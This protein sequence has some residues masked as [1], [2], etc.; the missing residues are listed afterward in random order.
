QNGNAVLD[1]A[2]S[3]TNASGQASMG[4]TYAATASISAIQASNPTNP[5][6]FATAYATGVGADALNIISGNGQAGSEGTHSVQPLVV[7]VRNAA[8]QVVAGRTINWTSIAGAA[9]PDTP[10]SVTN[11]SGRASMGFTYGSLPSSTITATDA[12]NGH[13]AVF[14]LANDK[15]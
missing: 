1:G 2:S 11:A 5:S 3:V 14:A 13:T 12:T 7:E 8:G 15:N 9:A 4:F 6:V 10:S